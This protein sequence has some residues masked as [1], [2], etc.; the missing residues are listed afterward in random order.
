MSEL[1]AVVDK[2]VRPGSMRIANFDAAL[3]QFT[4]YVCRHYRR[5]GICKE[6]VESLVAI[7][8]GW[9]LV[10]V[11]HRT[12]ETEGLEAG[13][14]VDAAIQDGENAMHCIVEQV[15]QDAR[16]TLTDDDCIHLRIHHK[17]FRAYSPITH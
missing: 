7:L 8:H 9:K 11:L 12:L 5:L 13:G 6:Q 16:I 15:K 14:E 2:T 3:A 10:L 4:A 17:S 1:T